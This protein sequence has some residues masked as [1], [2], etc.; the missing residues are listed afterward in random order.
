MSN[1]P[2][3][4]RSAFGDIAPALAWSRSEGERSE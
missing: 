2:T 1:E 3:A 4:A